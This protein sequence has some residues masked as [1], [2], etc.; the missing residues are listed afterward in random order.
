MKQN[1]I[2]TIALA[3]ITLTATAPAIRAELVAFWP[4]N[5]AAKGTA[6]A[7]QILDTV[8]E[9]PSD[10]LKRIN[11]PFWCTETRATPPV[12][13]PLN[14]KLGAPA[15]GRAV[16]LTRSNG[17]DFGIGAKGRLKFTDGPFSLFV[18]LYFTPDGDIRFER[19]GTFLLRLFTDKTEGRN[20]DTL[21]ATITIDG[22]RLTAYARPGAPNQWHDYLVTF[23]P[24]KHITVYVD[25]KQAG[26]Q[27]VPAHGTVDSE[28][29]AQD[30]F[31]YENYL[32]AIQYIESM[33]FYDHAL[34]PEEAAA[35]STEN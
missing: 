29:N 16:G 4:M 11:W 8:G 10:A 1:T 25:G 28:A 20:T 26:R 12:P 18:R 13:V 3:L 34:P 9:P 22:R 27:S 5:A 32:G 17:H 21:A 19:K 24:G 33:R 6:E 7:G 23:A 14:P 30:G 31:R 15:D 2:Q 35:L